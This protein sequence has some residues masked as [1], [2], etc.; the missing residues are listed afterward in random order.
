[1][2]DK[3]YIKIYGKLFDVFS[4]NGLVSVI[5]GKIN[6]NKLEIELWI[7]S[8]RVL[9]R[10]MEYA[11]LDKLVYFA[12]E[13]NIEEIIGYYY[14]T[15]KNGMVKELY[16]TLGFGLLSDNNGNTKWYLK[17]NDYVEKNKYIEVI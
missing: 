14:P 15:K 1:M 10:D 3:N 9:K 7:M 2:N 13:N 12:R 16:K 5:I 4:D 17:I 11:M 6:R 8:C